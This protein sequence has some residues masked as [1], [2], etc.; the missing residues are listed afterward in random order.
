MTLNLVMLRHVSL[1]GTCPTFAPSFTGIDA[2]VSCR[3]RCFPG[4][5]GIPTNS[6]TKQ[7]GTTPPRLGGGS[8]RNAAATGPSPTAGPQSLRIGATMRPHRL[9]TPS[10]VRIGQIEPLVARRSHQWR[11]RAL[12]VAHHP[13]VAAIC[14]QPGAPGALAQP[15][16]H[17]GSE[18]RAGCQGNEFAD[19]NVSLPA[20]CAKDCCNVARLSKMRKLRNRCRRRCGVSGS[21]RRPFVQWIAAGVAFRPL[22]RCW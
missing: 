20:T 2:H 21:S 19:G 3:C 18:P 16:P 8:Q 13:A 12:I 6:G 1:L 22:R 14:P 10:H 4:V 5:D 9:R 17:A 15:Q 7:R 11:D